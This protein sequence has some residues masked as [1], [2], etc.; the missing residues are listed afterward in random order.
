MNA[1]SHSFDVLVAGGGLS[2]LVAAF[3][4]Q[5]RGLAVAV[6]D[7]GDEPG[8]VIATRERDGFLYET[9]AN[10]ALDTTPLL[11]ELFAE[12]G[13]AGARRDASEVANTRYVVKDGALVALPTSPG[14]FLTTGAFTLGAKLRLFRE[15][16]VAPAPPQAE[17]SI[18]SFVRRRLGRE[19]LDYAIDPFVS[20]IYAGDPEQISVPAAFPRLHALEQ[21]YGSLI[22]GQIQGAR[23]RKRNPEKAKNAAKS[24]SFDRGMQVFPRALAAR[25][26]NYL[27][28][29]RVLSIARRSG[30]D[31]EVRA[32]RAGAPVACVARAL[33]IATPAWRAASFVGTLSAPLAQALA[34]IRYAP[35]SVVASAYR[36]E[37]VRHDLAGFGF[38]VPKKERRKLLGTL[39][40]S[41]M[42]EGRAPAGRVL[43]T[44]FVGGQRNPE[45][46]TLEDGELAQAVEGEL[47]SLLGAGRPLWHEIVRWTHAI[48]QY[49]I[50]HLDRVAAVDRAAASFPGLFW[51]ANWR[52]G[53]SV[54]DC[55]K[56]GH[57]MATTVH[58]FA[59]PAERAA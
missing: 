36:R 52:G 30:G 1:S 17:E 46:T 3:E 12:V 15:P 24:F 18:A 34:A 41:S 22:R 2:G 53:V 40:S 37:D 19:F 4:L 51:C 5:K 14:A 28:G 42:F 29:T 50:G 45:M 44:T 11:N 25:L 43:L 27:P 16:F 26:A 13:V 9:G 33:V 10:S 47:A 7:A 23:E 21:K 35:V 32:E 55:V 57:A 38:L 58:A 6:L 48:P 54:S 39:F 31:Y 56:N 20:G 49:T 59:A 8:G